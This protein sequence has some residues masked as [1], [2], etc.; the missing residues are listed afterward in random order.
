MGYDGLEPRE[1]FERYHL[2]TLYIRLTQR[3]KPPAAAGLQGSELRRRRQQ[4]GSADAH[5]ELIWQHVHD[6]DDR[7]RC[8]VLLGAAHG[9][10][11]LQRHGGV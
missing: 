11:Q 4:S 9:R 7:P 3:G 8:R 2:P 6:R 5:E 1:S 10:A